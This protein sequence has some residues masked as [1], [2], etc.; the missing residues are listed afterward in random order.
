MPDVLERQRVEMEDLLQEGVIGL[1]RILD[2]QP[3]P[4]LPNLERRLQRL[5]GRLLQRAGRRDQPSHCCAEDSVTALP[6][7]IRL[8]C[9][10]PLTG[11]LEPSVL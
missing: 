4:L 7:R 2:I 6:G 5:R 8:I 3:E 10:Q 11:G 1:L 9:V